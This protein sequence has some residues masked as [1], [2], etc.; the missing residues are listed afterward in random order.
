MPHLYTH[1]DDGRPEREHLFGAGFGSS[2][3]APTISTIKHSARNI[4]F[5]N[6]SDEVMDE[7]L[8]DDHKKCQPDRFLSTVPMD[9]V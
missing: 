6:R 9:I 8:N 4:L 2:P 1:R 3:V 5:A 7:E